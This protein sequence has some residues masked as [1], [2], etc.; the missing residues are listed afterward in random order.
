[1]TGMTPIACKHNLHTSS[2]CNHAAEYKFVVNINSKTAFFTC[3]HHKEYWYAK[4]KASGAKVK[5]DSLRRL[6]TRHRL[7]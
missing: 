3:R 1:M 6:D 7:E 4:A 2:G 5:V